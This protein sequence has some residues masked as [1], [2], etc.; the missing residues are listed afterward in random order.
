MGKVL[1][2]IE[3]IIDQRHRFYPVL[4]VL[5]HCSIFFVLN[6]SGLEFSEAGDNLQIVLVPV[7]DLL[8]EQFDLKV[9]NDGDYRRAVER[10]ALSE[11]ISKVLYPKDASLEG[12]ELRLKQ[13]CDLRY[14]AVQR[15]CQSSQAFH[16]SLPGL[17]Q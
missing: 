5:K 9:F 3:L 1:C 6:K 8:K 10:K 15:S 12:K 14:P 13:Q 4:A 16:L 2:L 17:P 11:S 7:V